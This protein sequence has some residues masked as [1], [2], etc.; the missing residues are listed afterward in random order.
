M[1]NPW[2]LT[3]L[4]LAGLFAASVTGSAVADRQPKMHDALR[5]LGKA[6]TTLKNADNDKG[7]HRVKAIELVDGAIA[8]V[9]AGSKFDNRH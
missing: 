2:K 3:S 9:E 1:R 5:L 6:R 4:L 8:E 7:G